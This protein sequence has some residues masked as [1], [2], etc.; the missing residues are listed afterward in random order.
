LGP[1]ASYFCRLYYDE[2]KQ[3]AE[4]IFASS[5][6]PEINYLHKKG[7]RRF[8][9]YGVVVPTT[10][11]DHIYLEFGFAGAGTVSFRD[12][13]LMSVGGIESFLRGRTII[14]QSELDSLPEEEKRGAR[15]GNTGLV[16][17]PDN[18]VSW[19]GIEFL[20]TGY[21]PLRHWAKMLLSWGSYVVLILVATLA[22][23]VIM[24]R[25][26]VDNERYPMPIAQVT[27]A[28]VGSDTGDNNPFSAIWRNRIM[29]MGFGLA[30]F[31]CLMRG[32]RQY[33]PEVPSMWIS[34]PL[35]PYLDGVV[36]GQAWTEVN[37]RVYAVII[38][39]AMFME[40]NV[41]ISL[42]IGFFLFR[43]Q[44][45]FGYNYL[46]MGK[47]VGGSFAQT[48]YPFA[49][50]QVIASY[51]TYGLLVLFFTRGYLWKVLRAAVSGGPLDKSKRDGDDTPATAN[52]EMPELF[53]Y[54]AALLL[55]IGSFA[56]I[57][58][59]SK[60]VNIP[61][62]GMLVYFGVLLLICFVAAKIRAECGAP[63]AAYFPHLAVVALPVL[64]GM[65][66]FAPKGIVFVTLTMSVFM[67]LFVPAVFFLIPGF[68]LELVEFG[69]RLRLPRRHILYT[70]VLGVL[71]GILIGGWVFLSSTNGLGADY[72]G[73]QTIFR[74]ERQAFKTYSSELTTATQHMAE[75]S[76]PSPSQGPQA[77]PAPVKPEIWAYTF[78]ASS[79]A[80]VTILRQLFAGFWFHP[81]G[82]I[83]GPSNLP[84]FVWGSVLTAWIIRSLTL[85]LGG[86]VTVRTKLLPFFTGVFLAGVTAHVVMGLIAVFLYF[87]APGVLRHGGVF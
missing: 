84:N 43:L 73:N 27:M 21:I 81:I 66:L 22:V 45:W 28:L 26:W 14:S 5:D 77:E 76:A 70:C 20:L 38:G 71:G 6:P 62:A 75:Q 72:A 83:L 34:V 37:F 58:L 31:W 41:L 15:P 49:P 68:Q 65:S 30:L 47:S 59:W 1:G 24:R 63:F 85:K 86:A 25:Q 61:P 23:A 52:Q 50:H 10:V 51:V 12:A 40:L 13:R 32:W 79:T 11:R 9:S 39:L 80:L 36:W 54:R 35:K 48:T 69:R 67:P 29:W 8:G 7:F 3:F 18:M 87:F 82:L 17:R 42:V 53:S 4:E 60:W 33:N 2:E 78:A 56:G 55:L 74:A 64:G 46:A 16:V 44:F 57:I 19:A